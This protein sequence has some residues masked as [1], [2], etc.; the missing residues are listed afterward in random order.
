MLG[1]TADGVSH[2]TGSWFCARGLCFAAV[3][4]S[5][6]RQ[7]LGRIRMRHVRWKVHLPEFQ[8]GSAVRQE[9]Q[10]R[11]GARNKSDIAH[12]NRP[13]AARTRYPRPGVLGRP[14]KARR[15]QRPM[16]PSASTEWS[17]HR[18]IANARRTRSCSAAI[19]CTTRLPPAATAWPR[20]RLPQACRGVEEKLS[21][22]M[23]PDGFKDCCCVMYDKF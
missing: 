22:K 11:R 21:C 9:R 2:A 7:R 8:R 4:G 12:P 14:I 19:A 20:T 15:G 5:R 1:D 23:R 13:R 18:P 3:L 10:P 17:V 16:R 6:R